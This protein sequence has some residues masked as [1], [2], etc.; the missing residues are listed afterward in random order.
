MQQGVVDKLAPKAGDI[1][2]T[3]ATPPAGEPKKDAPATDP[4]GSKAG[5]VPK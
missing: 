2:G 1:P 3:P 5:E 4:A